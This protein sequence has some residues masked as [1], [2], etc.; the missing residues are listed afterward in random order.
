MKFNFSYQE[1]ILRRSNLIFHYPKIDF[2]KYKDLTP[3]ASSNPCD[4]G[5]IAAHTTDNKCIT[6]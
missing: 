6:Q 2:A 3:K 1:K 5:L 4:A